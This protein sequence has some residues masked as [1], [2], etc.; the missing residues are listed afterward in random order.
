AWQ[1]GGVAALV[2]CV[3]Y[4][5]AR[6]RREGRLTFDALVFIAWTTAI[7][8][9]PATNNYLR[10]QLVYNAYLFNL[11]SWAPHI[12]GW[13]TPNARLLPEPIVAY[14]GIYGGSGVFAGL[15]GCTA[16]R[17]ARRRWPRLPAAGVVACG[18]GAIAVFDVLL[19][20]VLMHA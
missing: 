2:V 8:L 13:S 17:L 3:V 15:L 12:P 11:G 4:V 10:P 5:V 1:V 7:W 18:F 9:D 20:S 6:S 16:M 19:E 14:A